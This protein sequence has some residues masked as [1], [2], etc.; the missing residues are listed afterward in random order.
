MPAIRDLL[1]GIVYPALAAGCTW[2]FLGGAWFKRDARS[3]SS[4]AVAAAFLIGYYGLLGAVPLE[5]VGARDWLFW[6][7]AGGAL[8]S[9]LESIE[10]RAVFVVRLSFLGTLLWLV[11][12]RQYEN[13]W[14]EEAGGS[15]FPDVAL[16]FALGLAG[17]AA[18]ERVAKRS[19]GAA[20]PLSLW[21]MA[22]GLALCSLWSSSGLYAQLAGTV[23]AA[24]G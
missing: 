19:P 18:V 12:A 5:P 8:I 13:H 23:A 9:P 14:S 17:W 22:A 3:V 2:A 20:S 11:L 21:A 16:C 6:I 7:A 1:W 4:L 10:K 24:L 15:P